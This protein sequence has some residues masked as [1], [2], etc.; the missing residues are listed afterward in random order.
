MISSYPARNRW[1]LAVISFLSL[2]VLSGCSSIHDVKQSRGQGSKET[3]AYG[4][5]MVWTA[6]NSVM[7][8]LGL[9]IVSAERSDVLGIILSETKARSTSLGE[10]IA[11][12]VTKD[13]ES[14]TTVEVV[15]K[16]TLATNIFATDWS[17]PILRDLN[18]KIY[19]LNQKPMI[20]LVE[21]TYEKLSKKTKSKLISR[22]EVQLYKD[23][24]L[25]VI[26]ERQVQDVSKPGS[27]AGSDAG[28]ALASAVYVNNAMNSGQYNMWTDIGV[29][30]FGGIVGSTANRSPEQ[31]YLVKYTV[32][33][34]DGKIRS[35][36]LYAK[37]SIGHA[38]GECLYLHTVEVV[39]QL[40]CTGMTEMD[41]ERLFLN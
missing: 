8:D 12:F 14:Q 25:G 6:T 31:R 29:G 33:T 28:S 16:R 26:I 34:A 10:N 22:Y 39:D 4:F 21:S 38:I 18:F 36:S 19:A 27:S 40:N 11:V 5:E 3:F 41:V 20:Y 24:A 37:S 9:P 7:R 15:S 32:K 17:Q 2:F 23:D 13:S 30:V 35:N 1:L